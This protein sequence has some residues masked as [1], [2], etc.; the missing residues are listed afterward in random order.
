MVTIIADLFRKIKAV[1]KSFI[2]VCFFNGPPLISHKLQYIPGRL[3]GKSSDILV[4]ERNHVLCFPK[5]SV[6]M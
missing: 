4:G 5:N 6:S 1:A 3:N 2:Q